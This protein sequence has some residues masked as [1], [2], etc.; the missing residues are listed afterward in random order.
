MRKPKGMRPHIAMRESGAGPALS[1]GE[2][3]A[4]LHS[5]AAGERRV[6]GGIPDVGEGD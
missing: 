6:A 1:G 5:V 2:W 4:A 3:V